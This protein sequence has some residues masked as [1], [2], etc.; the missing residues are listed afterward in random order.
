VIEATPKAKGITGF[1]VDAVEEQGRTIG[2]GENGDFALAEFSVKVQ[3]GND[4]PRKIEIASA[5]ADFSAQ[6]GD[7]ARAIDGKA[8]TGWSIGPQ[9]DQ[10]HVIVFE[11]KE[12]LDLPEGAKLIFELEQST[13]GLMNRF[14]LGFS[15]SALPLQASTLPE[16]VLANLKVLRERRTDKQQGEL[17]R[18]FIEQ[19]DE[20]GRKLR[21]A[22]ATH[23]GAKPKYP[24]TTAAVMVA[25]E[26]KT[27]VHIRG[28]FLRP[29][30][31]VHPGTLGM[32]HAL[33]A[34]GEKPDRLDLAQWLIESGESFDGS[35][36]G[37]SRLEGSFRARPRRLG[38][39]LWHA[40]GKTV[41]P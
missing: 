4:E 1:R 26:R 34:R 24:E 36:R 5:R 21:A 29:G 10:P 15:T 35:R 3:F 18:F 31:E 41:A 22:L 20:E 30:D 37:E 25:D 12:A 33:R 11:L 27:H 13:V 19:Y 23:A 7:A 16:A 17:A 14:R 9:T 32:L 6:E 28:D 40:R 2:R 39:R 38:R 8:D